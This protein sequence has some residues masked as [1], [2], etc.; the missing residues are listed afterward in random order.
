MTTRRR[1]LQTP[2]KHSSFLIKRLRVRW[3][4]GGKRTGDITPATLASG[5]W[6]CD[7]TLTKICFTTRTVKMEVNLLSWGFLPKTTRVLFSSTVSFILE[8]LESA[9]VR[10]EVH[11]FVGLMPSV[12][13]KSFWGWNYGRGLG[14][15][16]KKKKWPHPF[17][18]LFQKKVSML[19]LKSEFWLFSQNSGKEEKKRRAHPSP[20]S[21]GPNPPPCE[22]ERTSWTRLFNINST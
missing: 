7:I 19:R 16:G 13:N 9:P 3:R 21:S 22:T 11:G 10:Q 15:P 4:R 17:L 20:L 5:S 6:R 1:H 2:I 8:E 18:L 12:K 14:P